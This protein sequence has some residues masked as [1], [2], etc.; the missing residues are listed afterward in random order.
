MSDDGDDL[1]E[2]DQTLL[3]TLMKPSRKGE[4]EDR[5]YDNEDI[6]ASLVNSLNLRS[7]KDILHPF[8]VIEDNQSSE[9]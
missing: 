3:S 1:K 8:G 9:D 7:D 6:K 4:I 5:Q 2:F